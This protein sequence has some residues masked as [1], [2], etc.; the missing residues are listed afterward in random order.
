[1]LE[2]REK[3]LGSLLFCAGENVKATVALH[4][5]S[6]GIHCGP[7]ACA[8]CRQRTRRKRRNIGASE[9]VC[10][11]GPTLLENVDVDNRTRW[12]SQLANWLQQRVNRLLVLRVDEQAVRNAKRRVELEQP[13]V[14]FLVEGSICVR[15]GDYD[16]L[17]EEPAQN[18]GR[19]QQR[20]TH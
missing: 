1:L 20:M 6:R 7:D 12:N 2:L 4:V 13:L 5:L 10:P 19:P 15:L 3:V 16:K 11:I 17:V 14:Y 8:R 9:E 18:P